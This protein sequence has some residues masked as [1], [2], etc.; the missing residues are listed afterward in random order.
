MM[1][2]VCSALALTACCAP[3]V[4]SEP[5]YP[6]IEVRELTLP[7][8]SL[9]LQLLTAAACI[10]RMCGCCAPGVVLER[11]YPDI[12]V[13]ELT[14]VPPPPTH[15][16][17]AVAHSLLPPAFTAYMWLLCTRCGVG[18][19]VPWHRSAAAD[20]GVLPY[21]PQASRCNHLLRLQFLHIC[22]LCTRCGVGAA[23]PRH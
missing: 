9:L 3:G 14:R 8:L 21:P 19:A 12:A 18:A 5:Q 1:L 16:S 2:A 13:R 7:P 15:L 17:P 22:L 20:T 6:D 4:V 23:V 11:Q 10:Y